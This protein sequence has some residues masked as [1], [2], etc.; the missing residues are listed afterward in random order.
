M[1]REISDALT[2]VMAV[3]QHGSDSSKDAGLERM[4]HLSMGSSRA[5]PE[6]A[7]MF[8]SAAVAGGA[9]SAIVEVLG[10]ADPRRLSSRRT[11]C[12]PSR[13]TTRRATP[14]TS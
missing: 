2:D 6:Q 4:I 14:T 1:A 8:R 7:R 11:R 9:V 13:S 3:L 12:T 10:A 5:G